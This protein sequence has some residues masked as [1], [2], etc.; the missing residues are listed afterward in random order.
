MRHEASGRCFLCD[1]LLPNPDCLFLV[2]AVGEGMDGGL[3]RGMGEF[4]DML[5]G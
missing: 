2:N 4:G 5:V 1:C 3:M